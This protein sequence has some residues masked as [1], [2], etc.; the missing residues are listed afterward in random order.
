MNILYF[1]IGS[2]L[3]YH[4]EVQFSMLSFMR[5]M[6]PSDRIFVIT[7]HPDLYRQ[8]DGRVQTILLLPEMADA[9]QGEHHFF[10]RTKI[11]AIEYIAQHYPADDFLYLDG[12]TFLNGNL[13]ELR[14]VLMAGGGLM[15]VKEGH[16]QTMK[17]RT[18]RMWKTISGKTFGCVTLNEYHEM[19][20]AGVVAIPGEHLR[21]TVKLALE[22]CDG[23]L[24]EEAEPVVIEQYSLSVALYEALPSLSEANP[25]IVHYWGNKDGWDRQ[26][27][28]FFVAS[29]MLG[30]TV[31]EE[32]DALA[33]VDL[34]T[35]PTQIRK[36]S[37]KQRIIKLLD[38]LFP[39]EIK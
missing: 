21:E 17:S 7:T 36:S 27:C 18:L 28:E 12:D 1:V 39:D 6:R 26:A 20:N 35:L 10:W 9:W 24:A 15:H 22:L 38:K 2:R 8:F 19:W 11:K 23:M 3:T 33:A 37:T 13:E 16:P 29:Q 32:L 34:S 4:M 31:D 30:R 5:Q 25:W 14:Q